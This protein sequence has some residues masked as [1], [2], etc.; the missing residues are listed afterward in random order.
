[1][2]EIASNMRRI[3]L[4]TH[5]LLDELAL[6][7]LP[8]EKLAAITILQVFSSEKYLDFLTDL[9]RSEKP[10]VGYHAIKALRSAVDSLEPSAYPQLT[11]AL[12]AAGAQ[13]KQAAVGFDTDRQTLLREAK[14]KL[15]V[16]MEMLSA[17]P[18]SFD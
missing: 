10:F 8:G 15:K 11:K 18:D 3:A 16:K 14:K 6:S 4:A 9:V 7:P 2:E 17:S 13:L 1:M 5:P 12:D